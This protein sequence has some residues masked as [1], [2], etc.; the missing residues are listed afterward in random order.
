MDATPMWWAGLVW[1]LTCGWAVSSYAS[2]FIFRLPRKEYPFGRKPYCDS[3]NALLQ[4]KDLFPIFSYW[5]TDGKC[6]YC[7]SVVPISY[8]LIELIYPLVFLTLYLQYGFGDVFLVASV[9]L[10]ALI[11]LVMTSYQ[12]GYFSAMTLLFFTAMGCLLRAAKMGDI[13]DIFISG[14]ICLLMALFW[15][16]YKNPSKDEIDLRVVPPY[17]WMAMAVGCWLPI[18]AAAVCILGWVVLWAV[19]RACCKPQYPMF[20]STL[21][22]ALSIAEAILFQY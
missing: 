4:P 7:G 20:L 3:C 8:Y 12:A 22:F 9:G 1:A 15:Y 10:S 13:M 11:I 19:L 17:V 18:P 16:R 21:S 5:Q 14:F 2:N 6:R